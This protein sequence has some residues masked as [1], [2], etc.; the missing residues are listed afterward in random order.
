MMVRPAARPLRRTFVAALLVAA[1]TV[2][3]YGPFASVHATASQ[4]GVLT[5]SD[6][7]TQDLTPTDLDPPAENLGANAIQVISLIF[8]GLVRLDANLRIAP[9]GASSWN[10][11]R[12]GRT[13]T[14]H[15]R[16]GLRFANGTPVTAQDFS[17]SLNRAFSPQ[18]ANAGNT[19]Y[20]LSNIVG[21][22]AETA[23]KARSVRGVR[24]VNASTLQIHTNTRS[25]VF[26]DQLA[27]SASYV[28][29]RSVIRKYGKNWTEHALGTGPFYVKRIQHSKEIDLAPNPYYWRGKPKLSLLRILFFQNPVT[30]YNEYR[31]GGLDVMGAQQFPSDKLSS[32]R[33]LPNFHQVA[34][35][36]TTYLTPN[37]KKAPFNNVHIRRAFSLAI[38]RDVLANK[39]LSGQY[40]PAH[41]IL[42]PGLPGYEG[43][44]KG[45]TFD[46]TQAK[47]ELARAGH[48]NGKGLPRITLSF[49]AG[50]AGQTSSA[51]VLQRYWKAYLGVNVQLNQLEAGAYNNL[52]S[53]RTYQLAFIS[54]GA[55][56]PDPQNF[57]SLQLQT[58]TGN[59]NGSFSDHTFDRLT[60]QA[61]ALVGN[62]ARRFAL[63]H[64]AEG[65][66]LNQAAWIVLYHSKANVFIS[67]RVH[68]LVINGGGVTA[69]NWATVSVK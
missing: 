1:L 40:V 38:N 60:T 2:T 52:L 68:G 59:N 9:D 4:A 58:G 65:I 20:Y 62:N 23:G 12:D 44:I 18:F 19:A 17:Y 5:M 28:V 3:G 30:A 50:D 55:D 57:L 29:P 6:E 32:A 35:L 39:F 48:P 49:S 26:L 43:N 22:A 10:V 54:W 34:Q 33:K 24:V 7:G 11:S 15:I 42:P 25:A 51:Q 41:T 16:R 67:S 63:Y 8:G 66:A 47:A 27:F 61:D 14:F 64:Q 56:Y 46:P 53:A 31:V 36:A 69:A 13:Y 21:G 45:E 37:E